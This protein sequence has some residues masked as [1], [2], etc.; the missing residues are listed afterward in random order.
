MIYAIWAI[1]SQCFLWPVL[2]ACGCMDASLGIACPRAAAAAA[3]RGAARCG[4]SHGL[5]LFPRCVR[6][7]SKTPPFSTNP[8]CFW[9]LSCAALLCVLSYPPNAGQGHVTLSLLIFST[10]IWPPNFLI[11]SPKMSFWLPGHADIVPDRS[12]NSNMRN[13]PFKRP[14]FSHGPEA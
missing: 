6:V 10:C 8:L 13:S 7:T 14:N 11:F 5:G 4:S 9:Y 1:L 2:S 12:A 3:R